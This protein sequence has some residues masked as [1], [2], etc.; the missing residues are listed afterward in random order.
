MDVTLTRAVIYC[1][2]RDDWKSIK[3]QDMATFFFLPFGLREWRSTPYAPHAVSFKMLNC[4]IIPS[5]SHCW[6]SSKLKA[7]LRLP[8]FSSNN[9]AP[10]WPIL[11]TSVRI[12]F[13]LETVELYFCSPLIWSFC[14]QYI[15]TRNREDNGQWLTFLLFST[16]CCPDVLWQLRVH[17]VADF[18]TDRLKPV[19][20][21]FLLS[22]HWA[23]AIHGASLAKSIA[24]NW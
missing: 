11:E 9:V 2:R 6:Q 14:G 23:Q 1:L 21:R 4:L 20:R 15:C 18:I 17:R 12:Q 13:A 8:L 16:F 3:R 5:S 24:T 22:F 19:P 10:Q 7:I